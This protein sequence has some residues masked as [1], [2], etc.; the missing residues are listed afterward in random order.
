MPSFRAILKYGWSDS[1]IHKL[2]RELD[3]EVFLNSLYI[4]YKYKG[5]LDSQLWLENNSILSSDCKRLVD[6]L[7]KLIEKYPPAKFDLVV[8]E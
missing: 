8:K 7:H 5:F 2:Y 6:I 1:N 4:G 3:E